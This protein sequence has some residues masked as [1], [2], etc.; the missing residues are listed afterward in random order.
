MDRWSVNITET[1]ILLFNG[2][3]PG[4]PVEFDARNEEEG[5]SVFK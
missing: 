2:I 4:A 3:L 1:S 5:E